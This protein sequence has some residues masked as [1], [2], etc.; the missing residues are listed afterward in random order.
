[1]YKRLELGGLDDIATSYVVWRDTAERAL[2]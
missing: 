2:A 1:V